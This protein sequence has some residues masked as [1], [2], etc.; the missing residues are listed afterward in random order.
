MNEQDM[1][2]VFWRDALLALIPGLQWYTWFAPWPVAIL[3]HLV[4]FAVSLM[5]NRRLL[6]AGAEVFATIACLV[7]SVMAMF[8][9]IVV[10]RLLTGHWK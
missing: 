7:V 1:K 3:A 9:G 2:R 10:Q 8:G 4:I 5:A 6:P